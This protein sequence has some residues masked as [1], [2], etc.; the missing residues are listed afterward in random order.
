MKAWGPKH[1]NVFVR[2]IENERSSGG[3][4]LTSHLKNLYGK[5]EILAVGAD[6]ERWPERFAGLKVGD[7]VIYAEEAS[8]P[9]I[10]DG[11]RI[12]HADS[13]VAIVDKETAIESYRGAGR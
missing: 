5:G 9:D 12:A 7:F 2:P 10:I 3:V 11:A 13:V 4:L 6:V 1:D 8:T